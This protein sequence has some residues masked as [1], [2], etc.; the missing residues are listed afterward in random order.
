VS[1]LVVVAAT[2][3]LT[4]VVNPGQGLAVRQRNIEACD[5][6]SVSEPTVDQF[7]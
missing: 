6:G 7:K 2:D 5:A 1:R 3:D 4:P